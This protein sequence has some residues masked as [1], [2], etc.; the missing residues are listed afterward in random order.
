[1]EFPFHPFPASFS[2]EQATPPVSVLAPAVGVATSALRRVDTSQ[3][4]A[5]PLSQC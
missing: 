3:L 4:Q 2:L 5:N 1:M